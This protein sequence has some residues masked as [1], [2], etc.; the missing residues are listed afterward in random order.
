MVELIIIHILVY[1]Y[2]RIMGKSSKLKGW[3][4]PPPF[5]WIFPCGSIVATTVGLVQAKCTLVNTTIIKTNGMIIFKSVVY[6]LDC[7]FFK[8]SCWSAGLTVQL[9]VGPAK[10]WSLERYAFCVLPLMAAILCHMTSKLLV[11]SNDN[12]INRDIKFCP[13]IPRDIALFIWGG[14]YWDLYRASPNR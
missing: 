6:S 12:E 7:W 8:C 11:Q 10:C 5:F 1:Y 13:S 4:V 2:F 14:G 3:S 9:L